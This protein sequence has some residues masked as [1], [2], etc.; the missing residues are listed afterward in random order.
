MQSP[1]I[2]INITLKCAAIT[3]V[4]LGDTANVIYKKSFI[5]RTPLAQRLIG[6][7]LV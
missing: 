3:S 4:F 6:N 5:P 2:F 1:N 7:Y